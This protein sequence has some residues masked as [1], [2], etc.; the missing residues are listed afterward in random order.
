M[1][2]KLGKFTS[3]WNFYELNQIIIY[4]GLTSIY[5]IRGKICYFC[6]FRDLKVF[7]CREVNFNKRHI[8]DY[9]PV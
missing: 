7:L 6:N 1:A 2:D 8:N 9:P 5:R 4:L 3:S